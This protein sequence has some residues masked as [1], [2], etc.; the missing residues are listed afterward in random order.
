MASVEI[1]LGKDNK[2]KAI[3]KD[4]TK[5][6]FVNLLEFLTNTFYRTDENTDITVKLVKDDNKTQNYYDTKS[7]VLSEGL[8]DAYGKLNLPR[9]LV[10]YHELGHHIYSQGAFLLKDKWLKL[11]GQT[12][13]LLHDKKYDH[14]F[15]W[16]EDFYVEAELITEHP[17]LTDVV[18]CI[19]KL[20]PEYDI[21]DIK[22]SFNYYYV[23]E[24]PSQALQYSDQLL[25][26][27]YVDKLLALRSNTTTRFGN[28]ILTT[29]SVKT[30]KETKYIKLLIEFYNWCETV[31]IFDPANPPLPPLTNPNNHIQQ[32]G[33]GQG[34][35]SGNGNGN[36]NGNGSSVSPHSKQVG[37]K[38]TYKE[39][40]HIANPTN[41]FKGELAEEA[42]MLH[43][44]MLDM[45]QRL[46]IDNHTLD[47][48]FSTQHKDSAII[49]P[50]V[51]VP[52]F[53][54]PH[55]LV[56]QV[57][58]RQ[59]KHTYMNVAIY[60]DI[61][62]ST[63]GKVHELM[64]YIAEKLYQDIPV[65]IT[66]YLYSSG[67]VSIIEVPYIPWANSANKPGVYTK[68]PL[69][70]QLNGGTNSS[71]IADVITQ[72]LSE[73]WLNIIITDG[74]LRDLM[75]RD[76]ILSLLSNVFVI[77]VRSDVKDGLLGVRIEEKEDIEFI[78]DKLSTI[79][80]EITT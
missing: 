44:E 27:Q 80:M 10:Y 67:N 62:G 54:N 78:N 64:H 51:I 30:S 35:G 52:N 48:L 28:G 75:N 69:F 70:Q 59:K 71:A 77:S 18:S 58:F 45:S 21:N 56:D 72:Q 24:A 73:K 19:K 31:G 17:Y 4:P 61:S 13:P 34:Q 66:Y 26:K 39:Q 68:N 49:Q 23:N 14:L 11:N 65:D 33:Q 79:N 46:Q 74:D 76:N 37:K 20:P 47:G 1:K 53:F 36:G 15:N 16:I 12:N 25:F 38:I 5:Q 55:R 57:L 8:V 7:I 41:I 43:K 42:K 40:C 6:A 32:G 2:P 3:Y 50:K 63:S 29:L 22:N 60:R 9:F